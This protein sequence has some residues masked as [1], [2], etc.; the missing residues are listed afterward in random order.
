MNA[1]SFLLL[2]IGLA[3]VFLYAGIASFQNPDAWIGYFP[4]ILRKMI[5]ENILLQ[6]FAG[7]EI[8]LGLWLLIGRALRVSS[9][10]AILT[11]VGVIGANW[12]LADIIFRD[13]GLLFCALELFIGAHNRK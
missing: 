4:L 9:L 8:F 7:Y 12:K 2:R 5:P 11:L 13:V 3:C 1:R 10:L 6:G